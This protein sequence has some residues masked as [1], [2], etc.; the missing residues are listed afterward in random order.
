MGKYYF[1][2]ALYSTYEKLGPVLLKVINIWTNKFSIKTMV[3]T[4]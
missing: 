1:L 3:I 2:A 4:F